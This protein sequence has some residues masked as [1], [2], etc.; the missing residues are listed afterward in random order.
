MVLAPTTVTSCLH[1][2]ASDASRRI[3]L[4]DSAHLSSLFLP[5][6]ISWVKKH[7]ASWS[8]L[9]T[10]K[11]ILEISEII[12]NFSLLKYLNTM[13]NILRWPI[14][15][16]LPWWKAHCC[17]NCWKH[18]FNAFVS[19]SLDTRIKTFFSF[20][21]KY[22]YIYFNLKCCRIVNS[23][24]IERFFFLPFLFYFKVSLTLFGSYN[25]PINMWTDFW[26]VLF[27]NS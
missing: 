11:V 26:L 6:N 12:I 2:A 23:Q 17:K 4:Y 20:N 1:V 8:K 14:R 21:L 24:Q 22:M 9:W 27:H 3:W 16:N 15:N 5:L 13:D 10:V 18:R 25:Y 19:C 7:P